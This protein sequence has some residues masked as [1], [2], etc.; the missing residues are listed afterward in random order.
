LPVTIVIDST[1]HEVYRHAGFADWSTPVVV[2]FLEGLL[3]PV[4]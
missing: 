4:G 3:E 1:G 2:E